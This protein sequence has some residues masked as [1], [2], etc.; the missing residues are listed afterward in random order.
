MF[1]IAN[2][3]LVDKQAIL[4]KDEAVQRQRS[5]SLQKEFDPVSK[6]YF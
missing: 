5:I 2:S 4:A 1:A 3:K 6:S